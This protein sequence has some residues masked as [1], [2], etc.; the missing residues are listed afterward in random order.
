MAVNVPLTG[1]WANLDPSMA[2][3]AL[4]SL[5]DSTPRFEGLLDAGLSGSPTSLSHPDDTR[6]GLWPYSQ[7]T[8]P[9]GDQPFIGKLMDIDPESICPV[10][11]PIG[12]GS[13]VP[14]TMSSIWTERSPRPTVEPANC[15]NPERPG[16]LCGAPLWPAM[17][18]EADST[19]ASTSDP[20]TDNLVTFNVCTATPLLTTAI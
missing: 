20:T 12:V 13:L 19:L 10:P 17:A 3:Y 16:V 9:G 6:D 14:I 4:M 5:L 8:V 15:S 7:N 2:N 11:F 1:G 18:S